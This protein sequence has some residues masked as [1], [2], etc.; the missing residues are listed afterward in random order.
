MGKI[1]ITL[2]GD[3]DLAHDGTSVLPAI[4]NSPK[5]LLLLKYLI[6]N[7]DKSVPMSAL[8]DALWPDLESSI[9]PENALKTVVSRTRSSLREA[10]PI[11]DGCIVSK[12]GSYMWND[13]LDCDVDVFEFE[14]LAARVRGTEVLD[15]PTRQAYFRILELYQADLAYASTEEEWM[16]SRSL[17]LH[18]LYIRTVQHL[19]ELLLQLEEHETIVTVCRI[20]LNV[21]P[22]DESLNL[23]MMKSLKASG[24][25]ASALMIYRHLTGAYYRH[26]GVEPSKRLKDFYLQ[27]IQTGQSAGGLLQDIR[28]DML[29]DSEEEHPIVCDYAT[30]KSVFHLQR[31]YLARGEQSIF[32]GLLTVEPVNMGPE[33]PTM[34]DVA[35]EELMKILSDNLRKGD[36]ITRCGRNQYALLLPMAQRE[37]GQAV[38]SRIRKKFQRTCDH[39]SLGLSFD[40]E[41][42]EE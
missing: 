35:M 28:E 14:D 9:N 4:A 26:L 21:A 40:L 37:G 41:Q 20:A 2:L 15:E 33:D 11:F 7:R 30:F 19:V 32:L 13:Q 6:L 39:M 23:A 38:I 27:L 8:M 24:Q 22:L 10:D 18:H 12:R 34:A 17:Y 31:R 25:S 1:S 29:R 3:F 5:G 42:M 16:V 36:T